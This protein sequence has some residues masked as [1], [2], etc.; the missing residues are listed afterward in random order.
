[1]GKWIANVLLQRIFRSILLGL[2]LGLRLTMPVI[3]LLLF[4]AST[5]TMFLARTNRYSMFNAVRL[6]LWPDSKG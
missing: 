2:G 4:P 1:M 6:T 3:T 5:K